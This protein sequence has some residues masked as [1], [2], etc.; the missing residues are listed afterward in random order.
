MV[1]D[2]PN[3][4][5]R[6]PAAHWQIAATYRYLAMPKQRRKH[7]F[8]G[9][10][11]SGKPKHDTSRLEDVSMKQRKQHAHKAPVRR[12]ASKFRGY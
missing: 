2:K 4:S 3:R 10:P 9:N 1:A 8:G 5:S 11:W 12:A 7:D 6:W